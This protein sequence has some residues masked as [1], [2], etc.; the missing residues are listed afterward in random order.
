LRRKKRKVY[1]R[2]IQ[3]SHCRNQLPP[4]LI[5]E[6][7]GITPKERKRVIREVVEESMDPNDIKKDIELETLKNQIQEKK[8]SKKKI[9]KK[10][11]YK[12]KGGFGGIFASKL[13]EIVKKE[14]KKSKKK[15]AKK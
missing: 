2:M 8:D 6:K 15:D 7:L 12:D 11:A 1:L 5:P 14:D 3:S 10:V 4:D 13:D 9:E